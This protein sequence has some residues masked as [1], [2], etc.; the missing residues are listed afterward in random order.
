V[1]TFAHRITASGD[2]LNF[3]P[4]AISDS[5]NYTCE[6]T[7]YEQEYITVE[8]TGKSAVEEIAVEGNR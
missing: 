1:D 6:V 4:V 7:V 8:G 5:G 2:S 3:S